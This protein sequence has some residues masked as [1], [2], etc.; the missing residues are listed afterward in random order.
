MIENCTFKNVNAT[1]AIVKI[2]EDHTKVL[3]S[4]FENCTGTESAEDWCGAGDKGDGN[5]YPGHE[6]KCEEGWANLTGE[7]YEKHLAYAASL[8]WN[9]HAE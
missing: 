2:E 8:G 9:H 4:L 6:F 7:E 3:G 1:S 5:E